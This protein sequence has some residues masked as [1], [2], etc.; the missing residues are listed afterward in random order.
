[1]LK[2][3]MEQHPS[4]E[5]VTMKFLYPGYSFLPNDSDF[6]D[7]ECALKYQQR[8]YNPEDYISVMEK[9]RKKN[10]LIVHRINRV[11]FIGISGMEYV[12]TNP[13]KNV[14]K[15]PVSWLMTRLIEIT[16]GNPFSI[17]M[18]TSLEGQHVELNVQ[19]QMKRGRPITFN[20]FKDL[21]IPLWP[22]GKPLSEKKHADLKTDE[23]HP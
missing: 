3:V 1:M 21:G 10:P 20:G 18:K 15:S 6:G 5:K 16:K 8:L 14:N 17:F 13:K 22:N 7:I 12:I 23:I 11:D 4:L 9:C 19:K 2:S